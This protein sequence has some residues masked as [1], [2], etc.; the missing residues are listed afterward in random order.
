MIALGFFSFLKLVTIMA[1]V[2][3]MI[4]LGRNRR[5]RRWEAKQWA[6]HGRTSPWGSGPSDE[7]QSVLDDI[8]RIADRMERRLETLEKIL[9]ADDPKWKE[10]AR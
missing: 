1:F 4:V 6:K 2:L 5:V 9:E 8:S 7:E 3:A 10:R